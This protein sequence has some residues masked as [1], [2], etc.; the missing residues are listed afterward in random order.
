MKIV[1]KICFWLGLLLVI[2]GGGLA[3]FTDLTVSMGVQ[4]IVMV[5]LIIG[6]GLLLVIPSKIYL[7]I[8]FLQEKESQ[9]SDSDSQ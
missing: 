8:L 3:T 6:I 1:M 7:L 4:G 5:S 2:L 9:S